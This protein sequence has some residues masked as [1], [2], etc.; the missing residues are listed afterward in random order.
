MHNAGGPRAGVRSMIDYSNFEI[1]PLQL[2]DL[3]PEV[4]IR[5]YEHHQVVWSI[6]HLQHMHEAISSL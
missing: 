5:R 3:L 2:K 6:V 1:S 4:L